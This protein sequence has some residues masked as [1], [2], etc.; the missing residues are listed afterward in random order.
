MT[1]VQE[2]LKRAVRRLQEAERAINGPMPLNDLLRAYETPEEA[3]ARLASD[4][5]VLVADA[6]EQARDALRILNVTKVSRGD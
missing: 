5:A 1:N 6:I 4:A 2:H 3:N